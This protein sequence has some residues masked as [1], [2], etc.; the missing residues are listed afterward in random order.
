MAVL[1]FFVLLAVTRVT[2]IR[3]RAMRMRPADIWVISSPVSCHRQKK[4][5]LFGCGQ[6]M[7]LCRVLHIKM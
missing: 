4:P 5:H 6:M 7:T 2:M 3:N 1:L